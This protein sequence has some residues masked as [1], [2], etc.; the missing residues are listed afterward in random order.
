MRRALIAG[1]L[2]MTGLATAPLA[3][4]QV[5]A[6]ETGGAETACDQL[7]AACV[8]RGYRGAGDQVAGQG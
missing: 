6:V 1:I 5:L 2:V 3:Q 7:L 4:A 8:F